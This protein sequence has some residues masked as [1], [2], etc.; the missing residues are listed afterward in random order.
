VRLEERGQR[1]PR[2]HVEDR[3]AAVGDEVAVGV[4]DRLHHDTRAVHRVAV[5]ERAV[6]HVQ[7]AGAPPQVGED[8]RA[9]LAVEQRAEL[10]ED[11]LAGGVV[12]RVDRDELARVAAGRVLRDP[13][14]QRGRRPQELERDA[15]CDAV[16]PHRVEHPVRVVLGRRSV[17]LPALQG[18]VLTDRWVDD[19]PVVLLVQRPPGRQRARRGCERLSCR[20]LRVHGVV[21]RRVRHAERLV[22]LVHPRSLRSSVGKPRAM[23]P[24]WTASELVQTVTARPR[25]CHITL[26]GL[27]SDERVRIPVHGTV[28]GWFLSH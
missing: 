25:E 10:G 2:R 1:H 4:R 11:A 19:K 16:V 23:L 22:V 18:E 26:R 14:E 8:V 28:F 17:D 12:L 27:G 3:V 21:E 6:P 7:R 5:R 20:R 9:G 24:L 15:A 13:G